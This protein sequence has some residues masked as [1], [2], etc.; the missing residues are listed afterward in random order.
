MDAVV[1]GVRYA[2]QGLP[3]EP[4]RTNCADNDKEELGGEWLT[5]SRRPG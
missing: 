5:E 1:L 3:Q 2:E 4:E